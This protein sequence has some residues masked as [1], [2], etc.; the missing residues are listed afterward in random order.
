MI[1]I[2]FE[3][4][5]IHTAKWSISHEN[6]WGHRTLWSWLCIPTGPS[7]TGPET[8]RRITS[9]NHFY[10]INFHTLFVS[11]LPRS[12]GVSLQINMKKNNG[13]KTELSWL[14][15]QDY[16]AMLT[17]YAQ[18][19]IGDRP[20]G[21]VYPHCFSKSISTHWSI[22]QILCRNITIKSH[23]LIMWSN[24]NV[25]INVMV[26]VVGLEASISL[27]CLSWKAKVA[28]IKIYS[29]LDLKNSDSWEF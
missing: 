18:R 1:L 10:E 2:L 9:Q 17:M 19:A 15:N 14:L 4:A 28:E 12:S 13:N 21:I 16:L 3:Q 7:A 27:V 11:T 29:R 24:M 23:L 20:R 26:I 22:D 6:Y 25:G 5:K 8:D